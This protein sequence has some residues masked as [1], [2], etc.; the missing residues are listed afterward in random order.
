[1]TQRAR[2]LPLVPC[3]YLDPR[4]AAAAA[5]SPYPNAVNIPFAELPTRMHE[6]PPRDHE[7]P[8]VGPVELATQV[9]A[10]LRQGGRR[11][12]VVA[13]AADEPTPQRVIGRLWSPNAWLADVAARLPSGRALDLGCGTGRDA[14]HLASLGWHVTG[15]D[16]LPDAV[17]RA[18]DLARR[19]AAAIAPVAWQCADAQDPAFVPPG[20][21]FDLV[22]MLRYLHRPL[23]R[24]SRAW[25]RP[26]GS[27]VAETF[28][29]LH[30]ERHGR[31]VAERD[32]L[33]PGELPE[34][35]Q[36]LE[37][38]AFEEGWRGAAHTARVWAKNVR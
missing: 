13:N 10:W 9:A 24:R 3:A 7:L 22:V 33:H 21:A 17:E 14:V 18:A 2:R 34:L 20:G 8:V 19:C 15:V 37:I 12:I 4:A 11:A 29:T 28:T 5:T 26:G 23:V 16:V 38:C 32:V 36:P 6:L 27:F 1:M 31:P 35:V 25:L 30:R